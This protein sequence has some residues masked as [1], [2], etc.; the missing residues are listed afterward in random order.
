MIKKLFVLMLFLTISIAGCI[1]QQEPLESVATV[2]IIVHNHWTEDDLND[3]RIIYVDLV[4]K[5]K[6]YISEEVKNLTVT[7]TIKGLDESYKDYSIT[8]FEKTYTN[9]DLSDVNYPSG[10]GFIIYFSE[11]IEYN[12]E[13]CTAI[14]AEVVLP[15]GRVVKTHE[16]YHFDRYNV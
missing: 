4:N 2:G 13:C 6:E 9:V 12:Q 1:R 15:N 5:R 16:P 3:G 14:F 8:L 10:E 7:L 11:L